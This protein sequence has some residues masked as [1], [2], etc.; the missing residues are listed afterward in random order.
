[1]KSL[2]QRKKKFLFWGGVALIACLTVVLIFVFR[3]P[4]REIQ[5]SNTS[6]T[7]NSKTGKVFRGQTAR[8]SITGK[9]Y[10]NYSIKVMYSS[11]YSEAAG[12]YPKTSDGKGKVIWSWRVGTRTS[13]GTYKIYISDGTNPF[14]ESFTVK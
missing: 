7:V 8:I 5:K 13:S 10:T 4:P 6:I 11:G 3:E 12:L 14:V 2:S 9:P 1:M